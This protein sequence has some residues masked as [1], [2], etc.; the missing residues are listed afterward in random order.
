MN[1]DIDPEI[2]VMK[3]MALI[4]RMDKPTPVKKDV[5]KKALED[6]L[7]LLEEGS[8]SPTETL[9]QVHK[10]TRTALRLSR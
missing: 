7:T 2:E 8:D 9:I 5:F 3:A 1:N 4:S 6:I 10:I